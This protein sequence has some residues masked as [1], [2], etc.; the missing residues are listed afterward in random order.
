[1]LGSDDFPAAAKL[2]AADDLTS[3]ARE[4][5]L[6]IPIAETLPLERIADAHD[7]VNAGGGGRVLLTI[8][9]AG[10]S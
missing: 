9:R 3:A 7:R 10:G 4:G 6:S 2:Q 5:A 1:L 8:P